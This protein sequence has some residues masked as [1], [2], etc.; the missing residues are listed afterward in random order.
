MASFLLCVAY[1]L[2]VGGAIAGITVAVVVVIALVAL[3]VTILAV[4]IYKRN[5]IQNILKRGT[6]VTVFLCL[7]CC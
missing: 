3:V 7:I 1:Y 2:H 6:V 4:V 5:W